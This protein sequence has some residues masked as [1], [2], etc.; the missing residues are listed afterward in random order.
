MF[1][2]EAYAKINLTLEVLSRRTDGL[3]E[4]A[5]VFQTVDLHDTI[6][7]SDA[8]GDELQ[9]LNNEALARATEPNL[10]SVAL[11]ALRKRTGAEKCAKIVLNKRIPISAGLGG[12]SADAAAV[13]KSL[14]TLWD[15][16]LS[17]A[18]L[19]E[20]GFEVGADVPFFI[21]GGTALVTGAGEVVKPIEAEN[22]PA[23]SVA[24]FV[25]HGEIPNKTAHAYAKLT[26]PAY[27]NGDLT[28]KMVERIENGAHITAED[29][30]NVFT[31]VV[32]DSFPH[33]AQD[34]E[35]LQSASELKLN[36]TGAGPTLFALLD[37][38]EDIDDLKQRTLDTEFR[39]I[40]TK[41][42]N[43]VR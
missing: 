7:I 1:T 8:D 9:I 33:W 19:A 41:M 17:E 27:T 38:D 22:P 23:Q 32:G 2:S 10:V 42:E 20:V 6:T 5:S 18:E 28:Q 43:G 30:Y 26:P 34:Y 24:L 36:L 29:T 16:R 25:W 35:A 12:G 31:K 39:L 37:E 13:L 40:L 21:F 11:D 4:L 14:N 3:H 15:L